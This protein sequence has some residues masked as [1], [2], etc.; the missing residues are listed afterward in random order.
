MTDPAEPRSPVSG[1]P[2]PPRY[3]ARPLR[4]SGRDRSWGFPVVIV[5]V[6]VAAGAILLG[7]NL[8][9]P[10]VP[11]SPT[12]G[13]SLDPHEVS[14]VVGTF[15][16]S[17]DYQAGAFVVSRADSG[18]PTEIGRAVLPSDAPP[19]ESGR[20]FNGSWG[21]TMVCPGATGSQPIRILFGALFPPEG[22]QYLGPPAAWSIAGD[23]LY[24]VVLN[25]G[26]VDP[27]AEVR[28]STRGGSIGV[29]MRAF[30][31]DLDSGESQ[32]SGCHVA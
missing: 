14:S 26:F 12:P 15:A 24:I 25:G 28:L 7:P 21:F 18:S 10:A 11:A 17:L 32:A 22:A 30:D 29:D 19:L 27:N 3:V 4:D 6:L 13:A 1:E 16:V 20:P 5:V 9:A 2:V 31:Y 23:G 8:L